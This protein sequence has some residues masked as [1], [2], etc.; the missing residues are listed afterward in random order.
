M[1]TLSPDPEEPENH[2]EEEQEHNPLANYDRKEFERGLDE[3]LANLDTEDGPRERDVNPT[4]S[5]NPTHVLHKEQMDFRVT[6]DI[7]HQY[8]I[9]VSAASPEEAV[10]KAAENSS[11]LE[12]EATRLHVA[13]VENVMP[14]TVARM[15]AVWDLIKN[16]DLNPLKRQV[17][18]VE[19][20]TDIKSMIASG[21]VPA[22]ELDRLTFLQKEI[23]SLIV[24]G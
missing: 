18:A 11:M 15:E 21:E 24:E 23:F 13:S 5:N 4:P 9:D 6:L 3:F 2:E 7:V 16:G 12:P 10:Q 22:E 19:I 8:V 20:L 14:M 17:K 1:P